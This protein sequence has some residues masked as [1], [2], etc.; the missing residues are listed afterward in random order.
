MKRSELFFGFLKLPVDFITIFSSFLLAYKLRQISDFIPFVQLPLNLETFPVSEQF[1]TLSIIGTLIFIVILIFLGSYSFKNT[2]K[3]N[4]EIKKVINA[5]IIWLMIIIT[6]YFLIREF[7]FSRLTLFYSWIFAVTFICFGRF[8]LKIIQLFLLKWDIGKRKIL[9]IGNNQ[10]TST[11]F[12]HLQKIP[13]YN[14]IG[15]VSENNDF[16]NTNVKIIGRIDNLEKIVKKENIE[17]IIQTKSDLS[18]TRNLDILNYCRENHIQYHFVPDLMEVHQT[19]I[20]VSTFKGLPLITLKP[21]ALDGW[22]KII[23]R[24]T[25]FFGALIGLILLSPIFIII[26]IIIKLDSKGPIF[27]N[28]LD[29]GEKVKRVG[30]YGKPFNFIKFRTMKPNSDSLR[31]SDLALNNTRIDGPLIKIKNDP[32]ITGF[33]KFLRKTSLDELPQLWSVLK[34]DMS[35]VGP[36]PHLPEEVA[37]YKNYQKFVLTLKPGITGLAQISGRSDLKFDEEVKLDTYYIENWKIRLDIK[38]LIKT[39]FVI[40]KK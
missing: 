34:G 10:I 11:L 6:Y 20:E 21:T 4:S 15:A 13:N 36:R 40:F 5:S 39:I 31:Y 25:D 3:F 30:Q 29:N 9:I 19:N 1:R 24:I 18:S 28:R 32:R 16:S 2:S 23:K 38:I 35:L 12:H 27:F 33:G 37:K 7:P 22:G 8:I 14:V 17:E 26:A